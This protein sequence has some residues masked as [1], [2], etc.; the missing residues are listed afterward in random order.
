M[1]HQGESDKRIEQ[2]RRASA[3]RA[4]QMRKASVERAE[5]MRRNSELR[6]QA[7]L[8]NR[9]RHYEKVMNRRSRRYDNSTNKIHSQLQ[10][11]SGYQKK[12]QRAEIIS[13]KYIKEK[14][15]LL[16]SILWTIISV[17][18]DVVIFSFISYTDKL[19]TANKAYSFISD[20]S[21]GRV[22]LK[23][24]FIALAFVMVFVIERFIPLDASIRIGKKEINI[25]VNLSTIITQFAAPICATGLVV[26]GQQNADVISAP[27][28]LTPNYL[29][30]I[31]G[32]FIIILLCSLFS[33]APFRMLFTNLEKAAN[34]ELSNRIESINKNNSDSMT[35]ARII[36]CTLV[37]L[38]GRA[39]HAK[40]HSSILLQAVT[41]TAIWVL[42]ARI[43]TAY[44]TE[45]TILLLL[46]VPSLAIGIAENIT[47]PTEN[48]FEEAMD[49]L[50]EVGEIAISKLRLLNL[51]FLKPLL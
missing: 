15:S 49:K 11:G 9:R 23:I 35:K 31:F 27:F 7:L 46:V 1:R 25:S 28:S 20:I 37:N 50:K 4:E 40:V 10:L 18:I 14:K 8:E 38:D 5:Q 43:T 42:V 26:A 13:R 34:D 36:A 12:I 30:T 3:E 51:P 47:R 21:S 33:Y 24:I 19:E 41:T 39:M 45:L 32:F 2:M 17:L 44:L 29:G 6:Q 22:W 48:V 16:G